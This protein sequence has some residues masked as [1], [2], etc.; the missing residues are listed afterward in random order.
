MGNIYKIKLLQFEGAP[1]SFG[2]I[3]VGLG[4]RNNASDSRILINRKVE[5]LK[6]TLH[7]NSFVFCMQSF[8]N[9]FIVHNNER[10]AAAA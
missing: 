8:L 10:A 7:R 5:L 6:I 4:Q 9:S 2:V 1:G 3:F